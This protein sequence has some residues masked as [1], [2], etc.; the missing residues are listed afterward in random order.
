M[1]NI[2]IRKKLESFQSDLLNWEIAEEQEQEED[3]NKTV[4]PQDGAGGQK[5]T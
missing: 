4:R 5:N 3:E 2:P 1:E